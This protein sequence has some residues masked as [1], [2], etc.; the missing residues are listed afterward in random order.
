MQED[1]TLPKEQNSV[2][3]GVVL[4]EVKPADDSSEQDLENIR[5]YR[6]VLENKQKDLGP[7][8]AGL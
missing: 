1:K 7:D 2:Q 5:A 6:E 4:E 3:A 8:F